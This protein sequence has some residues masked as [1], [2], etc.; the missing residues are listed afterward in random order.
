MV[1]E[2]LLALAI[3]QS[4]PTL[5]DEVRYQY[6]AWVHADARQHGLDPWIYVAIIDRETRWKTGI[7]RYEFNGSCSVGLGQIN[8]PCTS[9]ELEKLLQPRA[10]IRRMG[11]FF[12]RIRSTC[13][14]DCQNLGWLRAYNPG[15]SVYFNAV[16][17]AVRS[18]DAKA[19]QPAVLRVSHGVHASRLLRQERSRAEHER[20][21]DAWDGYP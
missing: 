12:E 13:T 9:P 11:K 16:C 15:D 20:R 1:T 5:S 19:S 10:N 8:L 17:D 2:I 7:T 6:A 4:N 14:H 21:V 3:R 18:Y